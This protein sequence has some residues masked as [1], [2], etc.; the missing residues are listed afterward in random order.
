MTKDTLKNIHFKDL[1]KLLIKNES[2]ALHQ[3]KWSKDMDINVLRVAYLVTKE[4]PSMSTI[5]LQLLSHTLTLNYKKSS[6]EN[7]LIAKLAL[8]NLYIFI[9]KISV[10]T[11][12]N[13]LKEVKTNKDPTLRARLN[14]FYF[15]SKL[16]LAK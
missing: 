5:S 14:Y 4:K 10:K 1:E 15:L 11:K 7:L 3:E 16:F 8:I 6:S 9:N 2:L 12:I 13:F